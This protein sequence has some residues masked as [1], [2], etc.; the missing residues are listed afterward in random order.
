MCLGCVVLG[1][2]P[3][4]RQ[5]VGHHRVLRQL[6]S[7]PLL[8]ASHMR[9]AFDAL[10]ATVPTSA[11]AVVQLLQYV[12]STW[13]ENSTWTPAN[14][15]CYCQQVRTN[16]D[17]E[18]WHRRLNQQARRGALPLYMMIR[19]LHD[20]AETVSLQVRLMSDGRL[21][22]Y[23]RRRYTTVNGRLWD[24]WTQYADG[25]RSA[26]SLLRAASRLQLQNLES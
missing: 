13:L 21:R 14:L 6:M 15:T 1:L 24:L 3:S 8:P 19:L 10:S 17:V 9:P 4:Y 2:V 16:N 25:K 18:G 12:Q 26:S 23:A 5:K 7:L 11:T 20:E 22:R